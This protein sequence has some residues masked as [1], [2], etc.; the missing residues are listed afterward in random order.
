MAR[1][2]HVSHETGFYAGMYECKSRPPGKRIFPL[3]KRFVWMDART[4]APA[5]LESVLSNGRDRADRMPKF[6][7]G[8]CDTNETLIS[9]QSHDLGLRRRT[10]NW[11]EGN[12]NSIIHRI[13]CY[14]R[15]IGDSWN[16]VGCEAPVETKSSMKFDRLIRCRG[17]P[18]SRRCCSGNPEKAFECRTERV[19]GC[20][21]A[22]RRFDPSGDGRARCTL[23]SGGHEN[24]EHS[25]HDRPTPRFAR[26]GGA[27]FIPGDCMASSS[28]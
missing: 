22:V 12:A 11:H 14:I 8:A 5:R 4:L 19:S 1:R 3:G 10:N 20:A 27:C 26:T 13:R 21:L 28:S 17:R 18:A 25:R 2:N 15:E 23:E 16:A 9:V 6:Y 7:V 24:D